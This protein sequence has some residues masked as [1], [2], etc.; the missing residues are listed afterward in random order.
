MNK[1]YIARKYTANDAGAKHYYEERAFTSYD[2]AFEFIE[3][4]SEEN[5]EAFLSE[6][7]IFLLNSHFGFEKMA[8][9]TFDKEGKLLVNEEETKDLK[10]YYV[11]EENGEQTLYPKRSP[12]SFS[13]KYNV[14]DLVFIR[15]FPWNKVSPT[16]EDTIGVIS[17]VPVSYNEWIEKGNEKFT[18]DNTYVVDCIRDGYLGHWHIEEVGISPYED[19]L[20]KKLKFLK[21]L[22]DYYLEQIEIPKNIFEKI[23]CGDLFVENIEHFDFSYSLSKNNL[24]ILD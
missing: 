17:E 1:I 20:P 23:I 8:V 6:I 5:D 24:A 3:Y 4:I 9:H 19:G 10:N 11:I 16:Y 21:I 18:W 12:E 7:A 15:A 2:N 22:S 13:G 14:G